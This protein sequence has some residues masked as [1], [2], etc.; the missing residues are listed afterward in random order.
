MTPR[1]SLFG[2][3]PFHVTL[4]GKPLAGLSNG[5]MSALLVYLAVQAGQRV[6]R[7]KLSALLWPEF[8][9]ETARFNLR[10]TFFHLRKLLDGDSDTQHFLLSGREWLSFN[11]DS[12]FWFDA[13]QLAD[14]TPLIPAS[15]SLDSAHIG[16]L[17]SLY[18]GEFMAGLLLQD[19]PEF[20]DWL[21]LQREALHRRALALLEQLSNIHEQLGEFSR[22]L[23]FALRYTELEPWNE[24]AHRR[25]MRLYVLNGQTGA[26]IAQ[27]DSCR[28]LLHDELGTSPGDETR[29]LAEHIRNG[30]NPLHPPRMEQQQAER[31]QV[32]VLYCELL[33]EIDDPDEA[34]ERLNAPRASL[35]AVIRQFSGHV[36]QTHDGGLLAYFGYPQ[37]RENAARHAVQAA[38]ALMRETT[39]GIKIRASVHTG[40]IIA[41]GDSRMPDMAGRVSRLAIQLLHHAAP[42][43]VVISQETRNLVAGYFDCA[44]LGAL[45]V[46][47]F[48]QPQ[49]IFKV[50]APSGAHTRL[51]A[52]TRL[53]PLVGRDSELISLLE[54]WEEAA[55]GKGNVV[56]IQGEAGIGKS[57]LLH[58]LK[59]RLRG[60]PH[61]VREL[62]CFPEF[63]LSPFYPLIATLEDI[64]SFAPEDTSEL[65]SGKLVQYLEAHYPALAHEATPLLSLLLALPLPERYP[66]P[67]FTPQKQ[68]ERT[69]AILLHLLRALAVQQ[70]VLFIV[71]D[72]HWV[73]PSTLELLALFVERQKDDAILTLLTARPEF[74]PPWSE[75][76]EVI[77]AP[78][79]LTEGEATE[80]IASIS[81][82]IPAAS[83]R[84]IVER[85]DGVPLFVEEMAKIAALDNQAGIPATLHDLLAARIDNLGG[86]KAT[87]QLAATIGREFELDLLRKISPDAPAEL[88]RSMRVLQDAG[89]ILQASATTRQFKHAL[90]Q[91]AAYQSQT[92]AGRQA[93]HIGIA[94]ALQNDFP[95]IVSAQPEVIAQHFN[96]GG[97]ARQAIAYWLK[98][99]QR[100]P[101]QSARIETLEYLRAGLQALT[102]LPDGIERDNLEFSL[103]VRLGFALQATQGFAAASASQA[104]HRAI[105]LAKRIS[106]TSGLFQS[107]LSLCIGIS[108]HP[109][110][111]NM[112]S[113]DLGQQLLDMA[114]ESGDSRMLQQAHHVVGNTLFWMGRFADS[115][116]HQEKSIALDPASDQDIKMDESGRIASVTSQAFLSWLMWLQGFPEQAQETSRL[117]IQ[118]ARQFASPHTLAY[119]LIMA[120]TLQR[121]LNKPEAAQALV[122]ECLVVAQKAELVLWQVSAT[123]LRGWILARQGKAEGV[124]QIRTCVDKMR[125]VMGGI[126]INFTVPLAEALLQHGQ[127]G[128]ALGVINDSINE[129][130]K[131]RDHHME[132]ELHRLKGEALMQLSRYD[133]AETCFRRAL[134]TSRSQGAKSL[135]LRAATSMARL[136]QRQGK[137]TDARPLL[138][139]VYGWFTERLDS[140]DFLEARC[141][142]DTL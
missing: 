73:D 35:I 43:E 112:E 5:K 22:A 81:T 77:M 14:A 136:W 130:E 109:D 18:R 105:D 2:F 132:A 56:L 129:G 17:V 61:A 9:A 13:A 100:A 121:W 72:L 141:L 104:L 20:E 49:E 83:V 55:R 62:R 54:L 28:L 79:P 59:D 29:Q 52:A 89:L 126:I 102:K 140:H 16:H 41:S 92:K 64:F 6:S 1:L 118:R 101:L 66:A 78:A 71:E 137:L 120:A 39:H 85:T 36:V 25:V 82:A 40:M 110:M 74:D 114:R 119:T 33:T 23:Q 128:E 80:L 96:A 75:E 93:A 53:T 47:G 67:N 107:L 123:M 31:R 142:L 8:P 27:Y 133:E 58:T 91:E 76:H 106:N 10:H 34:V 3:G 127:A 63:S 113:L 37:A 60:Q 42:C 125:M 88:S 90:I 131:K 70:P 65:K 138:Q 26:A 51:D 111:G 99:A 7:E 103:Q 95:D 46:P 11:R 134:E 122:E 48:A 4:D 50:I 69:I 19:C 94:Q 57:R 139:E 30:T 135:E 84:H 68:R 97:D 44:K 12:N 116:A 115:R 86:A 15:S 87:A 32:T 24:S 98:A 108:S 45:P 117:S 21:R 124:T 38:L